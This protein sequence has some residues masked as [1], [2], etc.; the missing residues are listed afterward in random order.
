MSNDK[1]NVTSI[2]RTVFGYK[3]FKNEIQKEATIAISE[4]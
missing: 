3:N 2:L 4:G 1:S